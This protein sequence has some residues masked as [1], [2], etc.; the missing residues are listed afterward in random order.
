MTSVISCGACESECTVSAI[1]AGDDK[2]VI[3]EEACIDCGA[4]LPFV[5]WTHRSRNKYCRMLLKNLCLAQVFCLIPAGRIGERTGAG[6]EPFERID[7][8]G[9]GGYKIIQDTR[10]FCFGWTPSFWPASRESGRGTGWPSLGPGR[11]IP[12]LIAT[13]AA[14]SRIDAGRSRRR[15]R[16]WRSGHGP[17]R[18]GPYRKNFLSDLKKIEEVWNRPPTMPSS[19]TRLIK[20]ADGPYQREGERENRPARGGL[21]A[22][23]YC[24]D[25]REAAGV[26]G[27]SVPDHRP[28]RLCDLVCLMREGG[29]E[30]RGRAWC[31][32][33]RTPLPPCS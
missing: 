29:L 4:W 32:R 11:I 15:W 8:L 23:G 14:V 17:Q 19:A 16:R 28:E 22:G 10:A 18:A 25:G 3:D 9:F 6:L 26:R 12:L 30:P 20:T 31:T 1:S 7:E 33:S 27:R 21:H 5:R 13:R 24:P 2:Y